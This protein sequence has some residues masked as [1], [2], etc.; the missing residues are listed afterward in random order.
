MLGV[1]MPNVTSELML[2][3]QKPSIFLCSALKRLA[4]LHTNMLGI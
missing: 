3:V 2:G 1:I 4:Y